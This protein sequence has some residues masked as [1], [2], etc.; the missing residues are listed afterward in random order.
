MTTMRSRLLTLGVV[1]ALV[2]TAGIAAAIDDDSSEKSADKGIP[3]FLQDGADLPPGLAKKLGDNT[4]PGLA[5]KLGDNTPPGQAKKD[6]EKKAPGLTKKD[7]EWMP[8]GLAKKGKIPPGHARKLGVGPT[9]G[10]E[11]DED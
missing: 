8:P 7:G 5:K 4:P 6:G 2:L 1:L 10:S 3:S 9:S 11:T